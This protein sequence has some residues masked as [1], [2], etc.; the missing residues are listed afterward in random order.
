MHG[1]DYRHASVCVCVVTELRVCSLGVIVCVCVCV[2]VCHDRWTGGKLQARLRGSLGQYFK[3]PVGADT[4]TRTCAHTDTHTH[5]QLAQ[6]GLRIFT[7][8][9]RMPPYVSRL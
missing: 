1:A 7:H 9:S 2:C 8:S 5:T 4:H 3:Q 6:L